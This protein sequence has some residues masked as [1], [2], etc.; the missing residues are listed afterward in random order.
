MTKDLPANPNLENLKKQAKHLAKAH[1]AGQVEAFSRIKASFPP[2]ADA[3]VKEILAADFSL[4]NAQLVVA[5]EYGF[6]TWKELAA[7]VESPESSAFNDAFVGDNPSLGWVQ[8]QLAQAAAANLPVL[9]WGESGTG[10]GLVAR[11][12]HRLGGRKEAPFVQVSTSEVPEIL[13]ESELFGHE[14]GAFTGA[15]SRKLGKVEVAQGGTVFIDE[16]GRVSAPLQAKLRRLVEEGSFERVGGTETLQADVRLVA[17]TDRDLSAMVAAGDFRQDLALLLER[18]EIRLPALRQRPADIPGLAEHF[19][20][21]MAVQLQRPA[22]RLEADVRQDLQAY[23]WPGNV[24]ELE[25]RIQR[26]V[27]RATDSIKREDIDLN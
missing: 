12:I 14:E 10:K 6:A 2:L 11:T 8:E 26:A 23:D 9:V 17:A 5:R 1:K 21:Q 15:R 25:G 22:P 18:L 20:A 7:A 16:I 19:I 3:S 27:V 4:C 24:R 13:L